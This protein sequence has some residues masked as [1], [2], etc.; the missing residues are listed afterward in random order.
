LIE[1]RLTWL[2]TPADVERMQQ[3]MIDAFATAGPQAVICA[4]WR[5]ANVFAPDVGDALLELLR[6]GNRQ[7][8]R[9]A[10]LLSLHEATFSL[11]V[12][13]LLRDAQN[14]A[15]RSFRAMQP[16]LEWLAE[17]LTP[18]EQQQ[19]STFLNAS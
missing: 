17:V 3:V 12:E 11:Q 2:G 14:P 7:F 1:A 13:R 16:M 10:A 4:D 9:S 15:R 18:M 19:A 8:K 5:Q 6:R